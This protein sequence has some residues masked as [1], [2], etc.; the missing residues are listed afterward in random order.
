MRFEWDENKARANVRKHDVRF[1]EALRV[2]ADPDRS[3]RLDDRED[4][5]EERWVTI[6]RPNRTRSR[7]LFVV[8]VDRE[9]DVRRIIS[10][11]KATSE[12]ADDYYSR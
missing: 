8:Y 7:M 1:E 6:G 3:E 11:R 10:A 5:G 4:F 9:L 12:E 2:F